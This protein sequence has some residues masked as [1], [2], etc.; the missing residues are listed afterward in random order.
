MLVAY[1]C[2]NEHLTELVPVV[3][4][5]GFRLLVDL[6]IGSR[7]GHSL[8]SIVGIG[9]RT[10]VVGIFTSYR[11][12]T[13]PQGIAQDKLR[14]PEVVAALGVAVDATRHCRTIN[15]LGLFDG[16]AWSLCT[17]KESV[18][19]E[20]DAQLPQLTIIIGIEDMLLELLVLSYLAFRTLC[21]ETVLV[22][23]GIKLAGEGAIGVIV[24]FVESAKRVVL[25]YHI[26]DLQLWR[27]PLPRLFRVLLGVAVYPVRLYQIAHI[28]LLKRLVVTIATSPQRGGKVE[29]ARAVVHVEVVGDG[30]PVAVYPPQVILKTDT[31]A[32]R[33]LQR[34]ADNSLGRGGIAG[35]RVMNHVDMLYL[36]GAQTGEFAGVANLTPI[37]IHLGVATPE[38]FHGSVAIGF[39][40]RN[41]RQGIAHGT[42]LLQDGSCH[43]GTHGV[44]LH[45]GLR[46]L[47]LHHHLLQHLVVFLHLDGQPVSL[48]NIYVDGLVAHARHLQQSFGLVCHDIKHT[49]F[50]CHRTL[51]ESRIGQ[52]QQY[53]IN[54]RERFAIFVNHLSAYI[55]S[56]GERHY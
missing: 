25:V 48:M 47:A 21:E 40:R 6:C 7:H 19:V 56:L 23:I 55:L 39:K 17:I 43:V 2:L 41:P 14:G 3:H 36:I 46:Q 10:M 38:H 12:V 37:D 31:L 24:V 15:V 35:T 45:M 27:E 30:V 18:E 20:V 8:R 52:R 50:V 11:E 29:T 32:L 34:D 16:L 42:G 1:T 51:H 5:E 49:L 4:E 26:V 54:I 9:I 44:A 53:Y 28:V 22:L 13:L 33:L